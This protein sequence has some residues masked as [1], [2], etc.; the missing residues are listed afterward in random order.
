MG[1]T[2]EN[3]GAGR[4]NYYPDIWFKFIIKSHLFEIIIYKFFNI[5]LF[6]IIKIVYNN[7]N[8]YLRNIFLKIYN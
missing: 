8:I 5:F 7:K 4:N 6:Y 3:G 2:S 1:D